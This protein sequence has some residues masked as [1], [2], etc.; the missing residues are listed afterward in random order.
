MKPRIVVAFDFS[1][2][3]VQALAWS[4]DLRR[5][6]GGPPLHLI[7]AINSRPAGVGDVSLGALLPNAQE[8]QVLERSMV[9]A[10]QLQGSDATAE[11]RIGTSNVG[12]LVLDAAKA[13]GAEVVVMGSHGRTGVRRLVLG[14]VAEHVLRH[15]DCPV[16]TVHAP[17]AK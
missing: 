10:A 13:A 11:V 4:A 17:H 12:D 3:A 8:I 2:A 1:P 6:T 9:E 14:S 5:A 16:V 7:H 15:A